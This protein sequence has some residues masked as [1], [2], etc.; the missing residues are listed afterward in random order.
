MDG[1]EPARSIPVPA[2]ARGADK[3]DHVGNAWN[4]CHVPC[5]SLLRHRHAN[6]PLLPR[7]GHREE[8]RRRGVGIEP[9]LDDQERG[10]DLSGFSCLVACGTL[11]LVDS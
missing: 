8:V 10:R 4:T 7:S 2:H 3:N 6:E 11:V 9:A 1:F 5:A